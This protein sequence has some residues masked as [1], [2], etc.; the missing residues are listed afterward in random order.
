MKKLVLIVVLIT[1]FGTA[2]KAI[3]KTF[4]I[5]DLTH[6]DLELDHVFT[7]EIKTL[8]TNEVKVKAVSE[9][10]F[11]SYFILDSD[12][13]KN[14]LTLRSSVDFAFKDHNDKLS[15]HKVQAIKIEISLPQHLIVTLKSDIAN[16]NL[17]GKYE[18]FTAQLTSGNCVLHNVRDKVK[19]STILGNIEAYVNFAKVEAQTR[20]GTLETEAITDGKT[21]YVLKSIKGNIKVKKTKE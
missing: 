1:Q 5:K 2:Q 17:C 6:L 10:E 13:E 16:L 18:S 14:K 8:R 15:A 19:I 21:H 20:Q 3:E 12:Q 11:A 4:R 9:G 7:L